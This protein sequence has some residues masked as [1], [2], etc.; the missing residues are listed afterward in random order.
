MLNILYVNGSRDSE[1]DINPAHLTGDL[2]TVLASADIQ[3]LKAGRVATVGADGYV[4]LAKAGDDDAAFA[5]FIILDAAGQPYENCPA[6][7]SGKLPLLVGGGLVETDEVVETNIKAGDKLY[8][9]DNGQLTK[10][11]GTATV[12]FGLARSANSAADKTVRVQF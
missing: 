8:I 12:A 11:K 2:K 9:G 10:T 4:T 5:G 3:K 6:I 1:F 7:A